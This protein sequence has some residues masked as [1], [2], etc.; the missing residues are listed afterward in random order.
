MVKKSTKINK[1]E[2]PTAIT[3]RV[4]EKSK[5]EMLAGV[6][7]LFVVAS[8]AWM[9]FIVMSG[10]DTPYRFILAAPA[11]AWA[12]LTLIRMAVK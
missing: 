1:E 11:V 9:S 3:R 5:M 4:G 12:S 8:I 10:L 7:V 6:G 2:V